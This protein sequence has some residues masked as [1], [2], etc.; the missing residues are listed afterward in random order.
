[1]RRDSS[2]GYINSKW[3]DR[4]ILDVKRAAADLGRS[5]PMTTDELIR[6]GD[7]GLA[8]LVRAAGT[9][10]FVPEGSVRFAPCAA[11]RCRSFPSRCSRPSPSSLGASTAR[12]FISL[13]RE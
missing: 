8:D 10:S 1:M 12:R 9:A 6:Y 5:V 13:P 4:G 11:V 3:T 7:G 2:A